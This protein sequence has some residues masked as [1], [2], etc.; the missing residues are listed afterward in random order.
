[1]AREVSAKTKL[2]LG[3]TG[4]ALLVPMLMH[5]EGLRNKP[6]KDATGILTVCYGHTGGVEPGRNYTDEEC[7]DLLMQD[8]DKHA[9]SISAITV[10]LTDGQRAA[11]VHFAYN[12]GESSFRSSTLVKKAN[13]GDLPGACAELSRWVNTTR[14]MAPG[15]RCSQVL[16]ADGRCQEQLPGLVRR[17]AAERALCER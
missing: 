1:M 13:T 11:F 15:E 7:L 14:A 8:I 9:P 12:V 10:P 2:A 4:L 16:L 3:A 17:R 5:F 6:Y